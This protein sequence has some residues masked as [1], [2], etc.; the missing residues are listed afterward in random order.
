MKEFTEVV[1]WVAV[2]VT[3]LIMLPQLISIY[4]SKNT[5]KINPFSF[6]ILHFSFS[7]WLFYGYLINNIQ[8]TTSNLI[9][10]FI[11]TLTIYALYRYSYKPTKKWNWI[12][13]PLSFVLIFVSIFFILNISGVF[14]AKNSSLIQ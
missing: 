8:I 7:I 1:G 14:I 2:I 11:S 10:T 4:R 3:T 6:W 5:K 12:Y 13:I 9:A